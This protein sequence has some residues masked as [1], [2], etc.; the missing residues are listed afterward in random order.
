V[1]EPK[2]FADD[3]YL[4]ITGGQL[5]FAG[6]FFDPALG[7]AMTWSTVSGAEGKIYTADISQ[8]IHWALTCASE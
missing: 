2:D 1:S 8:T 5:T 7:F 3:S 6:R 4:P